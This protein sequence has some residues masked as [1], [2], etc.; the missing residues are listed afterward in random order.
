MNTKILTA[1]KTEANVVVGAEIMLS[2]EDAKTLHSLAISNKKKDKK[3]CL[4]FVSKL[5]AYILMTCGTKTTMKTLLA[6]IVP[7]EDKEEKV[8]E[9]EP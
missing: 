6:E 4:N 5:T 3:Q 7:E 8:P 2:T 1:I 9:I